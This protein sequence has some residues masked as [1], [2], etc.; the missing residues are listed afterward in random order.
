M[1][2]ALDDLRAKPEEQIFVFL[3][4]CA[5]VLA[6][7]LGL[8]HLGGY[9]P[10][11]LCLK[12]RYAYY[13]GVIL[14]IG[15]SAGVSAGRPGLA[16][17]LI[18]IAGLFQLGNAGLGLYHTGIEW[19]WWAGPS[20]CTGNPDDLAN[21]AGDLLKALETQNIVRCDQPALKILWLSLAAWNV[22]I[23]LAL[24]ALGGR[25]AMLLAGPMARR[26]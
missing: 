23:G 9:L 12:E 18:A 17:G 14:A 25:A 13:A 2:K 26:A 8:E 3:L 22:P 1:S 15:A 5:A 16:A 19:H 24:A 7:A 10:C 21:N 20:T 4:V 11:E 6:I